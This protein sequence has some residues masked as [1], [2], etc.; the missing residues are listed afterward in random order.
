MTIEQSIIAALTGLVAG[1][2]CADVAPLGTARPYIVFQQVGG[3]GVNF[4]DQA[5]IPSK[6]NARIQIAVWSDTRAEAASLGRAAEDAM[7][8]ASGIAVTVIG[9]PVAA[10]DE[11]AKARGTRQDFSLW[12]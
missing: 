7:R 4:I 11:A 2:V 5:T 9:A 6:K 3:D 1:R 8:V 12:F 10:Y